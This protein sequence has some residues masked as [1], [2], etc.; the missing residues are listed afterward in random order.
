MKREDGMGE[1]GENIRMGVVLL[2]KRVMKV[3]KNCWKELE[4]VEWICGMVWIG[5]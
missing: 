4:R 3:G 1:V 5:I 2:M